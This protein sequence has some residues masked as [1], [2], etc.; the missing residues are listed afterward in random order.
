MTRATARHGPSYFANFRHAVS[1]RAMDIFTKSSLCDFLEKKNKNDMRH[2]TINMIRY[3]CY[4]A[5]M[6]YHTQTLKWVCGCTMYLYLAILCFVLAAKIVNNNSLVIFHVWVYFR[7]G[8]LRKGKCWETLDF[9][10]LY[11][12]VGET[13]TVSI[14]TNFFF[15]FFL[16]HTGARNSLSR[17]QVW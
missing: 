2:F 1:Y 7:N 3:I 13:E 15:F 12:S 17:L 11:I 16:Q 6:L 10:W 14:N 4:G 9:V 8:K 5:V